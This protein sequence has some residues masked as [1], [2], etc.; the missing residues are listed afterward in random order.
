MF[1][2]AAATS[3]LGVASYNL[4]SS[5]LCNP[6]S[7]QPPEYNPKYLT[8]EYRRPLQLEKLKPMMS[9]NYIICLQELDVQTADWLEVELDRQDYR[10]IFQPYGSEFSGYMG[11]AIAV[12]KSTPILS[13]DR[14]R[15]TTGKYWAKTTRYSKPIQQVLDHIP[16]HI[17]R[18]FNYYPVYDNS[19]GRWNFQLTV[20]TPDHLVSCVHLPCAFRNPS[21]MVTHSILAAQRV[22]RLSTDR[23]KPYVLAGDFNSKPDSYAYQALTTNGMRV[24]T[25]ACEIM[26]QDAPELDHWIPSVRPMLDA[27]LEVFGRTATVTNSSLNKGFLGQ[28]ATPFMD[29]IDYIFCDPRLSVVNAQECTQESLPLMPNRDEPS[30]HVLIWAEFVTRVPED[31]SD[32]NQDTK[33]PSH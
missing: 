14:H 29:T 2:R 9:K 22:Q 5:K 27:H 4:L 13:I 25:M 32:A 12:P 31:Y 21:T 18:W 3:V 7:F 33:A 1:S 6:E 8:S 11:V 15:L 16:K 23:Q 26:E 20:E 28:N 24:N 17:Q 30:D 19:K 10:L